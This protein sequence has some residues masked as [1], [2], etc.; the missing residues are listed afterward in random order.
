MPPPL[1]LLLHQGGWDELL[2][3]AVALGLAYLIIVWSGRRTSEEGDEE[4]GDDEP[5]DH[6]ESSAVLDSISAGGQD[7]PPAAGVAPDPPPRL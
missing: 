2:M 3:V 6:G 1:T 5:E 7:G 4:D